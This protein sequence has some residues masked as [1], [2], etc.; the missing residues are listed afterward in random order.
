MPLILVNLPETRF[1]APAEPGVSLV[2]LGERC[3]PQPGIHDC[4]AW[5]KCY[6][7]LVGRAEERRMVTFCV[8]AGADLC[9]GDMAALSP[10][11]SPA[12]I[13]NRAPS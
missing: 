3:S 13:T 8:T 12:I 5:S 2:L 7:G 9:H 10:V 6:S 1:H 11:K 4:P